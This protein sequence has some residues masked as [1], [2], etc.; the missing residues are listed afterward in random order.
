M[1]LQLLSVQLVSVV[2][3]CPLFLECIQYASFVAGSFTE[4]QV[5]CLTSKIG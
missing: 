4:G 3:D 2:Y 5:E 1:S